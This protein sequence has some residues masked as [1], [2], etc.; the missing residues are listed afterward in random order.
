MRRI[1]SS[2]HPKQRHEWRRVWPQGV[3][4]RIISTASG[5]LPN[6]ATARATADAFA[7]IGIE[8]RVTAEG[9]GGYQV[10]IEGAVNCDKF[11]SELKEEDWAKSVIGRALNNS[12]KIPVAGGGKALSV[13]ALYPAGTR[14]ADGKSLIQAAFTILG[15]ALPEPQ[16]G[17]LGI[18]YPVTDTITLTRLDAIEKEYAAFEQRYME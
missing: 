11:D 8:S 1:N 16:E 12:N 15:L 6:E 5:M 10:R 4:A 14:D 17:R 18:Y 2:D 7:A 13:R 3:E 9:D